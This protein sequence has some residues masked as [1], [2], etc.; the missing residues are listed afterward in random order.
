MGTSKRNDGPKISLVPGWADEP[1]PAAVDSNVP[2]P[3][4]PRAPDVVGSGVFQPSR[5]AMTGY[6]SSGSRGSLQNAVRRYARDGVGG[7]RRA[8]R[9]MGASRS[10]AA[11]LLGFVRDA[12]RDGA[13]AALRRLNLPGMAG[14]SAED[15]LTVL[16]DFICPPGGPLDEAIARQGMLQAIGDLAQAGLPFDAL[17][18][19]QLQ[20]VFIDFI[21]RTI[22]G[23][24]YNDIAAGALELAQDVTAI[25]DAQ[26]IMHG[27]IL[28]EVRGAVSEGLVGLEALTDQ[29]LSGT[30][31]T[32]YTAAFTVLA[33]LAEV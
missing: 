29:A 14:R 2:P 33:S 12:V 23:R 24:I 30:V 16:V 22:E 3:I 15:V 17:T 13:D 11:R 7:P 8:A 6:G 21:A 26:D 1:V 28:G 10:S 27:F 5:R 25:N 32:I 19:D 31:D 4:P 9:R 18:P 20:E